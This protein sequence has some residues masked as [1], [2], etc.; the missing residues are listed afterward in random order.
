MAGTFLRLY[1]A[2]GVSWRNVNH[3]GSCDVFGVA[4]YPSLIAALGQSACWTIQILRG[5]GLCTLFW[6]LAFCDN[7][8]IAYYDS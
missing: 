2:V 3:W 4:S 6:C 8:E 7:A 5:I 1:L